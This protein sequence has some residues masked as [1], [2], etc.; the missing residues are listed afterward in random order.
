MSGLELFRSL[1]ISSRLSLCAV[2]EEN[3]S[4]QSAIFGADTP[5][6][7]G[8]GLSVLSGVSISAWFART[9]GGTGRSFGSGVSVVAGSSICTWVSL[10]SGSAG[11][12]SSS[13][14]SGNVGGGFGGCSGLAGDSISAWV[15]AGSGRS[16]RS[17]VAGLSI[18]SRSAG[19]SGSSRGARGSL[20][21]GR[22]GR[23]RWARSAWW[24][25]DLGTD[26]W[27]LS[28]ESGNSG[29]SWS[30]GCSVSAWC[31]WWSR[32]SGK[33]A[34]FASS[35]SLGSDGVVTLGDVH[36]THL[37]RECVH[38]AHN[39]LSGIFAILHLFSCLVLDMAD[40][41]VDHGKC[42]AD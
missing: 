27:G 41:V 19:L 24:G 25:S 32:L 35:L 28:G 22:S 17:G 2:F 16:L 42:E 4:I 31:S 13:W 36:V 6:S 12:S 29:S 26:C 20:G 18:A 3:A 34:A 11:L 9:A 39:I 21:S 33:A 37:R 8:S 10:G 23:S 1:L 30:S 7:S 14:V 38:F 40:I 5:L 15:S